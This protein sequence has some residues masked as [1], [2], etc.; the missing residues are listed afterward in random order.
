MLDGR[1]QPGEFIK[2]G[3]FGLDGCTISLRDRFGW[4]VLAP[5]L[6]GFL[7]R[8]LILI[9]FSFERFSGFLLLDFR[10]KPF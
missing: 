6:G 3:D 7:K 10:L 8:L 9:E 1:G 5:F 4:L 2:I